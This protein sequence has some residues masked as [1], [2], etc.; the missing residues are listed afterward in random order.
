MNPAR[1]PS[2]PAALRIALGQRG[3]SGERRRKQ[4]IERSRRFTSEEV[5]R[6][7]PARLLETP[8]GIRVSS[9]VSNREYLW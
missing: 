4:R 9:P 7:K 2:Q 3:P 1:Q 8:L 6:G 5:S